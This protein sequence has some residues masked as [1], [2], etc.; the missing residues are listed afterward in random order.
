MQRRRRHQMVAL[1]F[2]P[3][4]QLLAV[5]EDRRQRRIRAHTVRGIL[6]DVG[7]PL[8]SRH[9]LLALSHQR[10]APC[11]QQLGIRRNHHLLVRQVEV[12]DERLAQ[13][14]QEGQR[15]AAE[16]HRSAYVTAVRQRN[17]G[18]YGHG[19][20]YRRGKILARGVLGRKILYIGL[21]KYAAAR[22]YGIDVCRIARQFVQTLGRSVEQH[23]HLVDEGTRTA[24]TVAVHTHV[25]CAAV[26]EEYHLGILTADV[27]DGSRRGIVT[28]H[29]C[30][31]CD[32]LLYEVDLAALGNT[33]TDGS[34]N[35]QPHAPILQTLPY[36]GKYG[37]KRLWYM[38]VVTFVFRITHVT[39]VIQNDGLHGRRP[40]IEPHP[41]ICHI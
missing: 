41:V 40:D 21:G 6:G 18:L 5:G 30:R 15:P 10:C 4:L 34:R 31:G 28:L 27:D 9:A 12:V 17:N 19:M 39:R 16:E 36:L 11:R 20:E 32:H 8:R 25:G 29:V 38:S 37:R 7:V 24:G 13:R 26:I 22:R 3:R 14:W 35:V 1:G 33:Q 23:R 2:A